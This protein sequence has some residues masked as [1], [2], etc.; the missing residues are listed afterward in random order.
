M[1]KRSPKVRIEK[2]NG[3]PVPINVTKSLEEIAEGGLYDAATNNYEGP[4]F[5]LHGK[6]NLQAAA[7]S[8]VESAASG[9]PDA[10]KE[11]LDR[12]LGKPTQR[13]EIKTQNMTLVGFLET[14]PDPPGLPGQEKKAQVYGRED[15]PET[16]IFT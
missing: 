10:R 5:R 9:N 15:E 14:I 12:V 13:Q 1:L 2:H 4:D 16:S 11:L 8:L 6:N 3:V 7:F